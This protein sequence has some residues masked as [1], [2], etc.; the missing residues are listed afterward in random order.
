MQTKQKGKILLVVGTSLISQQNFIT[1]LCK[2]NLNFRQLN[3]YRVFEKVAKEITRDYFQIEMEVAK[4]IINTEFRN[5]LDLLSY[6]QKLQNDKVIDLQKIVHKKAKAMNKIILYRYYEQLYFAITKAIASGKNCIFAENV[7]NDPYPLRKEIFFAF[8]KIFSDNFKIVN[9]YTGIKTTIEQNTQNNNEFI[10][11]LSKKGINAKNG[12]HLHDTLE[13]PLFALEL[14]PLLFKL[15]T[16]TNNKEAFEYLSSTELKEVYLNAVHQTKKAFGFIV[17]RQYPY[18]YHKHSILNEIGKNFLYIKNFK[19]DDLVCIKNNKVEYDYNIIEANHLQNQQ[20]CSKK[21]ITHLQNWLFD[22][23]YKPYIEKRTKD[24]SNIK[25]LS[26]KKTKQHIQQKAPLGNDIKNNVKNLLKEQNYV[27]FVLDILNDEE[28][29][30]VQL[31]F[32]ID[33]LIKNNTIYLFLNF[34]SKFWVSYVVNI[35]PNKTLEISYYTN[36]NSQVDICDEHLILINNLYKKI[37]ER[38]DCHFFTNCVNLSNTTKMK[39]QHA[40]KTLGSCIN[41]LSKSI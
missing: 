26:Q 36:T 20:I 38:L 24:V 3:V 39:D 6:L 32:A 35:S 22:N 30:N 1:Q 17:S 19:N 37:S 10:E 33:E 15:T 13:Y 8:I 28:S 34:D 2:T 16:N 40:Q 29:A 12:S 41:I 4:K 27:L 11:K 5:Y 7:F 21:F 31:Q 23:N 25:T 14:F 18:F 9:I